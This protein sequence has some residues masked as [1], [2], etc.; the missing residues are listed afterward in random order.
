VGPATLNLTA[1]TDSGLYEVVQ[2]L[3]TAKQP[4]NLTGWIVH[5]GAVNSLLD[6]AESLVMTAT[7]VDAA[8]GTISISISAAAAA[9][10]F[11][12]NDT[13]LQKTIYWTLLA[14]PYGTYAVKLFSGRLTVKRG[15]GRWPQ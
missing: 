12:A 6:V 1:Y 2:V 4:Q 15:S 8:Q 11:G 9:S 5:A 13:S 3:T 10:L 14:R 7:V